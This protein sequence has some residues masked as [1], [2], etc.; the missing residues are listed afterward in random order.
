MVKLGPFICALFASSVSAFAPVPLS[1]VSVPLQAK[2]EV[3]NT[4]NNIAIK[5]LLN[6]VNSS[7][8]LSKV[9]ESGLLSKAQAS[10]VSLSS[11]EPLLKFAGGNR[12][13]MILLEAA[14]PELLSLPILPKVIEFAPAALPLLSAAI[15]I[16]AIALQLGALVSLAS[17]A[18]AVTF[19]PD[20]TIL[21]IA[22]QT[23]LVATLGLIIP[24]ASAVGSVV[25]SKARSS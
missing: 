9:A 17:A 13:I 23:I 15:Q 2:A 12:E 21:E 4:G 25:L 6:T 19:I 10:G 16:P 1:R 7:G 24:A 11:L 3:D 18:A 5:N 20:D 14:T 8:V 22:A